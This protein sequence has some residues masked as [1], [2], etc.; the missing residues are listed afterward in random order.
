ME[1]DPSLDEAEEITLTKAEARALLQEAHPNQI[2]P[3]YLGAIKPGPAQFVAEVLGHLTRVLHG[4]QQPQ[5]HAPL[6]TNPIGANRNLSSPKPSLGSSLRRSPPSKPRTK[7]ITQRQRGAVPP[8]ASAWRGQWPPK[9]LA[10]PARI[11]GGLF[12]VSR[13]LRKNQGQHGRHYLGLRRP[14]ARTPNR[15]NYP[16]KSIVIQTNHHGTP[17]AGRTRTSRACNSAEVT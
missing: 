3:Q 17:G 12:R 13:S 2:G 6:T 10:A 15:R 14:S 5:A 9:A 11:A 4:A 7:R 8:L 16:V 1:R